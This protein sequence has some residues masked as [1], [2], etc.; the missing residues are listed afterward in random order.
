MTRP[1]QVV[2][3]PG[4]EICDGV[5]PIYRIRLSFVCFLNFKTISFT[6]LQ[7]A[8]TPF[9]QLKLTEKFTQSL[10]FFLNIL[11]TSCEPNSEI[12]KLQLLPLRSKQF[13]FSC[14]H[15]LI[16]LQVTQSQLKTAV[17]RYNHSYVCYPSVISL[18]WPSTP[19]SDYQVSV[20]GFKTYNGIQ[21]A[22]NLME[23]LCA[24]HTRSSTYPCVSSCAPWGASS[25]CILCRS[26]PRHIGALY[27]C[28]DCRHS[29]VGRSEK[30][31][32]CAYRSAQQSC[33][34]DSLQAACG[35]PWNIKKNSISWK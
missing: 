10:Y 31:T 2:I 33:Y 23:I 27:A 30:R 11:S 25:S 7:E 29:R 26:Q 3:S 5:L 14:L 12:V 22:V 19:V 8:S 35:R 17:Q 9:S 20:T 1:K 28:A 16:T 18:T 21:R 24:A 34:W 13:V 15:S 6:A 32:H 4:P